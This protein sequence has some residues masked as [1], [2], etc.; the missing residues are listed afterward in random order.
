[1]R[2]GVAQRTSGFRWVTRNVDRH[3]KTRWRFRRKGFQTRYLPAPD[4]PDFAEQYAAALK[5]KRKP[6]N[7]AR[8]YSFAH[9]IQIYRQSEAFGAIKPSTKEV[10]MRI[11]KRIENAIGAHSPRTMSRPD[12]RVILENVEKPTTRNRIHS[13]IAMLLDL[14]MNE[15]WIEYNIARTI[16]PRKV[17]SEGHHCWTNKERAKFCKYWPSGTMQRR[18]YALLFFTAQRG[19]DVMMMGSDTV[20]DGV[21]VLTQEKTG[22]TLR[23]PVPTELQKEL[24]QDAERFILTSHGKPFSKKG[25]QQWFSAA[26]NKAGLPHCTAHGLRKARATTL[27]ENGA[28]A[29]EIMAVTGHKTMKEAQRYVDRADQANLAQSAMTKSDG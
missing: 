12:L 15:E 19:G 13:M 5:E 16:K 3:G 6:K 8:Q 2:I 24:D 9:L 21:I 27:A 11:L 10:Y 29:L 1:M 23:L 28:T 18:A 4:D 14:A 20:Q 25:F 26:C 17:H 7:T 22:T